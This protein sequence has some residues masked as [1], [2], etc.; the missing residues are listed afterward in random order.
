[1][2]LSFLSSLSR[3][4]PL[5]CA[6]AMSLTLCLSQTASATPVT[7]ILTGNF[8]GS[9]DNVALHGPVTFQ[10][11]SDTDNVQDMGGYS[12]NTS[13]TSTVTAN[14]ITA[15]FLSPSFGVESEYMSAAFMNTSAFDFA[16]NVFNFDVTPDALTQTALS[17]TGTYN[18]LLTAPAQTN[19]GLLQITGADGNV[20]FSTL[21]ASTPE[22]SG[23]VLLATGLI[24]GAGALRR[25][26]ARHFGQ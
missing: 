7:Y 17:Y 3:L 18:S 6:A 22:P 26:Y 10:L 15:N 25:R 2:F 19:L 12:V 1:M 13:G 16:A 20:T 5:A 8:L 24:S 23:L 11:T 4:R 14:G 9:L 21:V